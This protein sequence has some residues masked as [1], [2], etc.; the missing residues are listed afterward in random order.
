MYCVIYAA[1]FKKVIE[2]DYRDRFD[3][4]KG[5]WRCNLRLQSHIWLFYQ[6]LHA[7]TSKNKGYLIHI[8]LI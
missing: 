3:L 8:D 5:R 4:I 2:T 1:T 6:N 7:V